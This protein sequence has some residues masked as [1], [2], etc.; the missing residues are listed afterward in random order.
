MPRSLK[1]KDRGSGSSDQLGVWNLQFNHHYHD[2]IG[3]GAP[4]SQLQSALEVSA[5]AMPCSIV[6]S[7]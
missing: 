1:R 5:M 2:D 4:E 6:M 3:Y 7:D